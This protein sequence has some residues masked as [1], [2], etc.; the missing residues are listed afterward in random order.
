MKKRTLSL[1]VVM[2][3]VLALAFT[4]CT[5]NNGEVVVNNGNDTTNNGDNSSNGDNGNADSN[6]DAKEPVSNQLIIGSTTELAGDWSGSWQNNAS[7][8]DVRNLVTGY[9]TV[10]INDTA[11]IF[12]NESVVEE[13]SAVVNEDGSKTHTFKI[14]LG[15]KYTSGEEITVDDYIAD[16]L[17]G[18]SKVWGAEEGMA[19]AKNTAGLYLVGYDE[20]S[21]AES[22]NDEGLPVFKG[23]RKLS[24]DTFSLT[25]SAE[26]TPYFYEL[27]QVSTGPRPLWFW[28]GENI[29]IKDDG[30]GCY[31]AKDINTPEYA[32]KIIAARDIETYYSSG[33]YKIESFDKAQSM[34]TLVAVPEYKGDYKG[35][36]AKIE[37]VII[38]KV[39]SQTAMDDLKTGGVDLL[40]YMMSGEEI[41]A[42]MELVDTGD[43]DYSNFLR[44]G[45]GKLTLACDFGP[46][47]YKEVRQAL[48]QLL[49]RN[50]F[51]KQFTGGYGSIVNGP[52]GESQWFYQE[53]KSQIEGKVNQYSYDPEKAKEL[54]IAAGFTLDAEGNEWA[55]EGLRHRKMEDG[56]LM[57]LKIMW[58]SSENNPVSELLVVT[59]QQNPA[60]AELGMEIQQDVMSF[61]ELL[62]YYYRDGSEDPKY[63]VPTYHMF[64][65]A[66]NFN[67]DYD[68]TYTYSMDPDLIAMGYNN[69]FLIDEELYGYAEDMVKRSGDERDGYKEAFVNFVIRWNEL[70]PDIPLYS[71]LI[72]DFYNAKLKG[73]EPNALRSLDDALLDSY[74]E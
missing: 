46:T 16:M 56:S 61:G 55:G 51:A 48:A 74:I 38:K 44:A 8:A 13:H 64:N 39:S 54:I 40:T 6:D 35:R 31:F 15:N 14:K 24:D 71:N 2:L 70:I 22:L 3:L 19:G 60:V 42:G 11:D 4:G 50:D 37:K 27:S 30:E 32:E 29:E 33:P 12:V 66:V 1:V 63:G 49:D 9:G 47:Q 10:S 41:N 25:I 52:Y 20:F 72:H 5:N 23:V 62:S 18:S 58:S 67:V 21:K 73:Y 28:L 65:L 59:L 34:V 68:M 26:E 57:P 69:N 17:L 53:T 36:T 45:Y 7:D 43:F